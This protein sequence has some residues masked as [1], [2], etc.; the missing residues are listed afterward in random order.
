MGIEEIEEIKQRDAGK[1][2]T[3]AV[4]Q[5][6]VTSLLLTIQVVN[7]IYVFTSL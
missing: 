3:L 4:L 6:A 5:R 1:K 2:T 7:S